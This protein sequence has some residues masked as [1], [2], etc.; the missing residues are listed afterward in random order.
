[1]KK[2]VINVLIKA[3]ELF[4][5]V[6]VSRINSEWVKKSV[7][8]TI[9]RLSLFGEALVDNDPNDKEQIELIARQTL[10]SSEFQDLE[11]QVTADIA[12]KIEDARIASFLL[13]TDKLRLQLFSVIGDN[14]PK[15][16]EQIKELFE[17]FI[18]TEEFDTIVINL[19]ELLVEKYSKNEATN[20][21]I[22][23]LVTGLVNS[24]DNK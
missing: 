24:D 17:S 6:I 23:S 19:T 4:T 15:N 18:K 11:K 12:A 16:G 10:L 8:L 2:F 22:V 7:Q 13:E 3:L 9:K 5:D 1:M 14:D 20:K 21:F